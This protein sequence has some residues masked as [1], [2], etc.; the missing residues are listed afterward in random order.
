MKKSIL[1]L[2]VASLLLF[3][4][5]AHLTAEEKANEAETTEAVAEGTMEVKN[6]VDRL[7]EIKEMDISELNASEKKE[8]RKEVRSISKELKAYGKADSE[9]RA[10][11]EATAQGTQ[12]GIYISG[13]AIIIILLLI[14]LL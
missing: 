13:T 3:T 7:G 11:A 4:I 14:L 1:G 12:A 8:L 5:P 6:L 10:N 9:A 2:M